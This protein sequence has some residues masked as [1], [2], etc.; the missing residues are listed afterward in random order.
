MS[1]RPIKKDPP[2]PA[3]AASLE[4][5]W[6]TSSW[7]IAALGPLSIRQLSPSVGLPSSFKC[8]PHS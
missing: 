7:F 3:I 8:V 5:S 4:N 1:M 2:A 6:A